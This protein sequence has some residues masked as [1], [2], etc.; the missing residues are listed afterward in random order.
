MPVSP[1]RRVLVVVVNFNGGGF[2]ARAIEL[3]LATETSATVD[4]VVVDNASTDGS[5]DSVVS[6]FPSVRI[7]RS[8]INLGFA[9]GNNLA[10][11]DLSQVDAVALVNSDCFVT[12]GWLTPLIAELDRDER[13]ATASPKIL[14]DGRWHPIAIASPTFSPGAGDG[15]ELGVRVYQG[16]TGV[17]FGSGFSHAEGGFRWT[18]APT[19]QCFMSADSSP[20]L[21]LAAERSKKVVANDVSYAVT[22][23]PASFVVPVSEAVDII[24][25]AGND[26]NERW[27]GVER[28]FGEV[29]GGQFDEPTDIAGWCGACVLISTHYLAD[30]GLLDERFFL[31]FEDTDLSLRGSAK[32]WRYRYQPASIVRH[33]HGLSSNPASTLSRF[34]A[35]R[36]RLVV[37]ARHAPRPTALRLWAAAAHDAFA[38]V[39]HRDRDEARLRLRSLAGAARILAA[40]NR[41]LAP[42]GH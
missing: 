3:L 26:L 2:L 17:M 40:G 33:G 9:G 42:S 31:Y 34:C 32:G 29:D 19:A 1:I 25:N 15:R 4:I 22:T 36:N 12:P 24:N 7:I 28:G 8:D 37:I 16:R 13:V 5:L 14:F 20:V 11:R 23:E 41:R 35:E 18:S 38:A 27:W 21:R 30:V 39:V 10:L 6:R